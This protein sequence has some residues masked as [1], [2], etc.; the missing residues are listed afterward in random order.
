MSRTKIVTGGTATRVTVFAA[1]VVLA[2]GCH[3]SPSSSASPSAS[4]PAGFVSIVEPWDP[5]HP[6][7]LQ[8]TPADCYSQPSTVDIQQCLQ[9]KTESTD[10]EIDVIQQARYASASPS[11]QTAILAQDGAWLGARQLVCEAALRTGRSIDLVSAG[12]CLLDESTARLAVV[13][14]ST[15]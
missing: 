15:S 14:G 5:G 4:A 13:R 2:A 11:G 1:L 9:G 3:S 8:T 6:A 7:Q 12:A 10:A